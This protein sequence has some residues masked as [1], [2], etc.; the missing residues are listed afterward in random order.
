MSKK[1]KIRAITDNLK[2]IEY[3]KEYGFNVYKNYIERIKGN[4]V[5]PYDLV[6]LNAQFK[7]S[8][9]KYTFGY[10]YIDKNENGEE[11]LS[12]FVLL[13]PLQNFIE[14]VIDIICGDE[15]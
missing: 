8:L 3:I 4:E 11:Y 1:N 14:F 7:Y 2:D 9:K 15:Y 13:T 12:G 10:I 5:N 6:L